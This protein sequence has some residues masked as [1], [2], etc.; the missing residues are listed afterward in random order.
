MQPA[1]SGYGYKSKRDPFHRKHS[2]LPENVHNWVLKIQPMTTCRAT[3]VGSLFNVSLGVEHQFLSQSLLC[4]RLEKCTWRTQFIFLRSVLTRPM[5]GVV[6]KV[7]S[8]R[9]HTSRLKLE[10]T[11]ACIYVT[12]KIS[13]LRCLFP[14]TAQIF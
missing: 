13:L 8:S 2:D 14:A 5:S 10:G 3:P 7:G 1:C 12:M 9:R 4:S 6:Q 11:Y